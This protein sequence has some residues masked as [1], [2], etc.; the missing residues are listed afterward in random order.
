MATEGSTA[1]LAA[2]AD[3]AAAGA[4]AAGAA[5]P[6]AEAADSRKNFNYP[7]IR[8]TDMTEDLRAETV[9]MIVTAVEKHPGNFEVPAA[10]KNIKENMDKKCGNSWHV[11]IGEGFE[12]EIV[13]EVKNLLYMYFG[14]TLGEGMKLVS[15]RSAAVFP[16]P[17][18]EIIAVESPPRSP[19]QKLCANS[20][21]GA[22]EI[23]AARLPPLAHSSTTS[24]Q[25]HTRGGNSRG[26]SEAVVRTQLK[27]T[28]V[29]RCAREPQN[30][31]LAGAA[32]KGPRLDGVPSWDTSAKNRGS[33]D[34]FWCASCV[35]G[36]GSRWPSI[37][38]LGSALRGR[39]PMAALLSTPPADGGWVAFNGQRSSRLRTTW[40]GC[41]QRAVDPFRLRYLT[42]IGPDFFRQKISE[43][44]SE[45]PWGLG[46]TQFISLSACLT[47]V[48]WQSPPVRLSRTATVVQTPKYPPRYQELYCRQDRLFHL[49]E[50]RWCEHAK[51]TSKTA[52]GK[53]D[54]AARQPTANLT[55]RGQTVERQALV[56]QAKERPDE[57]RWAAGGEERRG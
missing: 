52:Q 27:F 38:V 30:Q 17:G 28:L 51:Q 22:S 32:R 35:R 40:L 23:G 43:D 41:D 55:E 25:K 39:C 37:G 33:I 12:F 15:R 9:D 56:R 7:L 14:G 6:A 46:V 26:G 4:P 47:H 34:C 8:F 36:A 57:V 29:P 16:H 24:G 3:K 1:N 44:L 20:G 53:T 19:G 5:A 21:A 31:L 42:I 45:R 50:L 18:L 11:V 49:V 48:A 10:A 2:G 13:Y 54:R